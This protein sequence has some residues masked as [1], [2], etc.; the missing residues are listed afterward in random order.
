M[1]RPT[2]SKFCAECS[3]TFVSTY[4]YNQHVKSKH[5]TELYITSFPCPQ[6]NCSKNKTFKFLKNLKEHLK[7]EHRLT[8]SRLNQ[9]VHRIE[10]VRIPN[11][12]LTNCS[13][14]IMKT[15]SDKKGKCNFLKKLVSISFHLSYHQQLNHIHLAVYT[16]IYTRVYIRIHFRQ[17]RLNCYLGKFFTNG[18]SWICANYADKIYG[19]FMLCACQH[20]SK[21]IFISF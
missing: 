15:K 21:N 1:E 6:K 4:N 17:T 5:S 16:M 3:K 14:V 2:I 7:K 19:K 12:H 20:F 13:V 18:F 11:H 9:A 8:G 10:P